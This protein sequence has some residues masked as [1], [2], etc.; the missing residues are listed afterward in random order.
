MPA[1]RPDYVKARGLVAWRPTG[2]S[3]R[4]W[5]DGTGVFRNCGAVGPRG[6]VDQVELAA[7]HDEPSP[8]VYRVDSPAFRGQRVQRA[9]LRGGLVPAARTGRGRHR[10]LSRRAAGD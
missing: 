5:R 8:P 10:G 7:G 1:D 2:L 4:D 9:Y 6:L 3:I